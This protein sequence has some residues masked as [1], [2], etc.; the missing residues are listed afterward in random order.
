MLS[1]MSSLMIDLFGTI[2]PAWLECEPVQY[3]LGLALVAILITTLI[4]LLKP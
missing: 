3:L 1:V 4:R 2:F